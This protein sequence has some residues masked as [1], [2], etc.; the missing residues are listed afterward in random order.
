VEAEEAVAA[1]ATAT[2]VVA[3]PRIADETTTT[4][5]IIRGSSSSVKRIATTTMTRGPQRLVATLLV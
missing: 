1:I 5:V 2:P 4:I 3:V